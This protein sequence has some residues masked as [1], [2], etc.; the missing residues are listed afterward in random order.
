M[1]SAMR[2]R[3]QRLLIEAMYSYGGDR[4]DRLTEVLASVLEVHQDFCRLITGRAGL[5]CDVERFGVETQVGAPGQRRLVDLVLRGA[6]ADGEIVGSVFV[7]CKYNPQHKPDPYWFT[8]DQADRQMR[9]LRAE[10]GEQRLIGV[11]SKGDLDRLDGPLDTRPD[12]DPRAVYDEVISWSEVRMLAREAGGDEA[13]E[14]QARS[15][16]A[17]LADRLLLE[18]LTYLEL[19]GDTMG[20]LA[21]DDLFVLARY[22]QAQ[23]RVDRLLD[24]ATQ[25]LAAAMAPLD[26]SGGPEFE[27]EEDVDETTGA[28]RMWYAADA[29]EETWLADLRE[30]AIYVTVT[31]AKYD[32]EEEVGT[33]SV[34]AGVGWSPGR[35]GKKRL[36]GSKWEAAANDASVGLYW[37]GNDCNVLAHKPLQEI[38]ESGNTIVAQADV[39]AK[40][41]HRSI[42]TVLGLAPPPD[43]DR[44]TPDGES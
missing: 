19:E 11:C 39:L 18:F 17:S 6:A 28:P 31:G 41:A 13:W 43:V 2:G 20:A 38:T 35:A 33:P 36:V 32:E 10:P 34:Y 30:G 24:R 3:G 1:R 23:D 14:A 22:A 25:D 42:V 37:D 8:H 15:A 9:A 16:S 26:G 21:N 4:E 40:W 27:P 7:E 12:F 5:R 44:E 29:P